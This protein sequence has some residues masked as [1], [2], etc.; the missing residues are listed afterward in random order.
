MLLLVN[1]CLKNYTVHIHGKIFYIKRKQHQK[2]GFDFQ[3]N[4]L[5]SIT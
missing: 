4:S 3:I 2:K 5:D 1:I